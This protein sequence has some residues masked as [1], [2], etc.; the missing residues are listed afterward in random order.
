MNEAGSLVKGSSQYKDYV[1]CPLDGVKDVHKQEVKCDYCGGIYYKGT[2]L[3]CPHCGA[4]VGFD[5]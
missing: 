5:G 3:N 1:L 4:S 2:V